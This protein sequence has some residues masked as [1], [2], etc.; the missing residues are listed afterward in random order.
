MHVGVAMFLTDYSIAPAELARALEE[1]GFESLWLP[2]HTHIPLSRARPGPGR[3]PAEEILRRHGAVR[4]PGCGRGRDP[5]LKIG[6]GVCLVLQRDPI[7]TAKYVASSTDLRGRFLF[8]VGAGWNAEEMADHGTDFKSRN[9][10]CASASRRCARSG[11]RR[12]PSTTA[13]SSSSAR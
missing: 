5:R 4:R 12:S 7:Q 8:G 11:R 9:A 3:R 10:L 2:E 13:S 6:T 1:R